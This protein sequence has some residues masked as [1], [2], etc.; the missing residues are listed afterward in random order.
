MRKQIMTILVVGLLLLTGCG[1]EQSI[2]SASPLPTQKSTMETL[3]IYSVD[4]DSMSLIPVVIKKQ[5]KVY[6]AEYITYLVTQ[7]LEDEDIK[8]DHVKQQKD[9]VIV[10]FLSDAKP[11]KGCS[12]KMETLILNC[13]ASSLLD[14][15]KG[16]EKI[17][18]RCGDKAYKSE[19]RTFLRNQIYASV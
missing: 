16:C 3:T 4:S 11:V 1:G 15:V 9:T 17:V 7:N 8:I 2:P 10:S 12:K 6:T 19:N 18:Y 5:K 13:F 14:N